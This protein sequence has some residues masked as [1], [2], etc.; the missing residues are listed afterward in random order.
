MVAEARWAALNISETADLEIS[1][2][3]VSSVYTET[4]C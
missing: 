4:P 3:T 1:H 2:T